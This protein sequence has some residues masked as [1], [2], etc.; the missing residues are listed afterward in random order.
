VEPEAEEPPAEEESGDELSLD[1]VLAEAES[2]SLDESEEAVE[3]AAAEPEIKYTLSEDAEMPGD[4]LLQEPEAAPEPEPTAEANDD[5]NH[6][7]TADEIDALFAAAEDVATDSTPEPAADTSESGEDVSADDALEEALGLLGDDAEASD[8]DVTELIDE[9]GD[10]ADLSE[11]GDLLKKDDNLDLVDDDLMSMLTG[12]GEEDGGEGDGTPEEDEES[13]KGRKKRRKKRKK[14]DEEPETDE[15]GNPI[16]KKGLLGKLQ[17]FLFAGDDEEE[18]DLEKEGAASNVANP[19]EQTLEN[20]ALLGEDIQADSG[21][22]KKKKEKKK[23]EK[24]K[25]EKKPKEKKP[26]KPKKEKPVEDTVP[27]KKLPKKKVAAV[28]IFFTSFLAAVTFCTFAFANVGYESAA[29]AN[30]E[31]G[32]YEGAYDSLVGLT[33][34]SEESRDIYNRSFV[35]MRLQRKIDAYNEYQQ[36]EQSLEAI[37][38]LMQGVVIH[39]ALTEYAESLGVGPDFEALYQEIL[40]YLSGVYGVSQDLATDISRMGDDL[41][42]TMLLLDIVDP[43]WRDEIEPTVELT[44]GGAAMPEYT[45]EPPQPEESESTPEDGS[46]DGGNEDIQEEPQEEDVYEDTEAPDDNG[47]EPSQDD[48]G[49]SEGGFTLTPDAGTDITNSDGT[50]IEISN[51]ESNTGN[52]DYNPAPSGGSD[53]GDQNTASD[54]T[55]LY[56]FN[57]KRGADGTYHQTN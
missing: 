48:G 32:D 46:N 51:P 15:E 16:K 37:D 17:E 12:E 22:K 20:A 49:S 52:N 4:E 44:E 1:D 53:P 24:P 47:G 42:Y 45:G 54:G 11:M 57:V 35:L 25:K 14:K 40:G 34:L 50:H 3:E 31:K 29:K 39:D 55:T 27:E 5:P 30:F 13:G 19:S 10:D 36:R 28:A 41:E 43:T 33:H 18:T 6:V 2:L 23:K 26:K 38:S 8:Q 56:S 9:L 21:K 7:M